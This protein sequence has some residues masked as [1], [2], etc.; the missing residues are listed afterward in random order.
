M[1]ERPKGW[2]EKLT[3][4]LLAKISAE[5]PQEYQRFW[6]R[7]KHPD[8]I[9]DI[10]QSFVGFI[11]I[12]FF[13]SQII[14]KDRVVFD[15]GCAYA[16]QSYYFRDH[17]LYVGIDGGNPEDR[18]KLPGTEHTFECVHCISDLIKIRDKFTPKDAASFAICSYVPGANVNKL[19]QSVFDDC[20]TYYPRND[21]ASKE[22]AKL[23]KSQASVDADPRPLGEPCDGCWENSNYPPDQCWY[24][25]TC[26]K[27]EETDGFP[28]LD[29]DKDE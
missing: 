4:S 9:I 20:F 5:Y 16:F 2:E 29:D 12:Y 17:L 19:T 27:Y 28:P 14:P 15:V 25:H 6:E 8:S 10:D 26:G 18:L 7:L 11:D 21:S 23:G 22:L 13:L 3:S 24:P 1:K